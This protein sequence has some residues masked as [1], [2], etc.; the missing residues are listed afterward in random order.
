MHATQ[1]VNNQTPANLY[2]LGQKRIPS[3]FNPEKPIPRDPPMGTPG[4]DPWGGGPGG[5]PRGALTPRGVPRGP[6]PEALTQRPPDGTP[7]IRFGTNE[8]FLAPKNMRIRQIDAEFNFLSICA[9][10]KPFR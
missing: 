6:V 10:K 9:V 3:S 4:H 7:K 1:N 2:P 8:H 5:V